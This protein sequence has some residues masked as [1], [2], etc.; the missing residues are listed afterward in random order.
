MELYFNSLKKVF[1]DESAMVTALK[2][3][4]EVISLEQKQNNS[5]AAT[6][7]AFRGLFMLLY[8]IE[9][10]HNSLF[11]AILLATKEL[12]RSAYKKQEVKD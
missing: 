7:L 6:L 2:E 12:I 11:T 4:V 10:E 8:S 5:A 1:P 9:F 3:L